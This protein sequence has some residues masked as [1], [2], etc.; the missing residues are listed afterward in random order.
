MVDRRRPAGA[1]EAGQ[2]EGLTRVTL[3]P[4]PGSRTL[5]AIRGSQLEALAEIDVVF[6]ALHGTFGEDGTLQ[7][8]LELADLPYVGA[9][10]LGSA[11]GM[12]KALFKDVMRVND[13]PVLPSI[14]VTRG[15]LEK[16]LPAVIDAG[17]KIDP[18]PHLHQTRQPGFLGGHHQMPQPVRPDGRPDGSG[19][20]RPPGIDRARASKNRARSK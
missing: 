12:D 5:Y 4:Y 15:Q 11:V 6:P 18:L 20:L 8:L 13:V 14:V 2:T 1:L 9:G 7:G 10:V 17:R 3:L 19:P 16:D